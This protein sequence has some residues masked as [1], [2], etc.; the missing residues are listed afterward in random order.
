MRIT[1]LM[2][3]TPVKQLTPHSWS[4]AGLVASGTRWALMSELR[5][6]EEP[7]SDLLQKLDPVD[8]F[9]EG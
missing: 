5:G 6:A 4:A 9:V 8:L 1:P 7:L 2:S 3:I